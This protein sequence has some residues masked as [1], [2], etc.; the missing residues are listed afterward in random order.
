MAYTTMLRWAKGQL[1]RYDKKAL[2]RLCAYFEI[3]PGDILRYLPDP[4]GPP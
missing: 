2:T 3:L 4:N 1:D